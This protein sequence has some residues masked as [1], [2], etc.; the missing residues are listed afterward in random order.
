MPGKFIEEVHI[1]RCGTRP[2][3][4]AIMC[5]KIGYA[6]IPFLLSEDEGEPGGESEQNAAAVKG[7]GWQARGEYDVHLSLP[8]LVVALKA[9]GITVSY[10]EQELARRLGPRPTSE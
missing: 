7:V 4:T 3:G 8:D 6:K 1:Y 5:S 10:D 2:D 9:Q